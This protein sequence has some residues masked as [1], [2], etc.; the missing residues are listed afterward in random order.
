MTCILSITRTDSH[1]VKWITPAWDKFTSHLANIAAN[2]AYGDAEPI[3]R[4]FALHGIIRTESNQIEFET[5]EYRT[6]FLLR[7]S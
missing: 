4:E 6:M 2:S 5:E 7:W 3:D 1:K